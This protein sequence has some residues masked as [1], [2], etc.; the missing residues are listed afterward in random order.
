LEGAAEG[1]FR[2]VA[3]LDRNRRDRQGRGGQ[4]A[5]G[6]LK[7]QIGEECERRLL[8]ASAEHP[9]EAGA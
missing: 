6:K 8:G 7:P 5:L 9:N 1:A 4:L 2:R 3:D